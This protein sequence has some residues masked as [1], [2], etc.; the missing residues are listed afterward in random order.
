MKQVI[1]F[2]MVKLTTEE[3]CSAAECEE[4]RDKVEHFAMVKLTTIEHCSA[5]GCEEATPSTLAAAAVGTGLN[6]KLA[7]RS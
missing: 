5:A 4:A 3:H 6:R 2:A 1:H 7:P